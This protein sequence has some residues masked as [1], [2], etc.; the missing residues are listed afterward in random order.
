MPPR[1]K[2]LE[3]HGYKTFA[4]RTEFQ[5]PGVITAIVGPNGSGKSNIADAL[6]WVLGEQSF[7]LLRGRKTEDMIF[8][9]SEQRSRAGMASAT[10]TFDNADGWLPIDYSEVAITRRAYRDGQNEYLINGQRV[11]LRE[12]SELLA[13]SGLAERTYTIIGQGLVDAA[14][15]LKPE[16]RR[17]LFE[18]AAGIGL[19]RS[20]REESL[21]RLENTRRNLER[22]Q[23]ILVELEPRMRSLEKQARRVQES[24][25]LQAELRLL[26]RDLY[27]YQWHNAQGERSRAVEILRGQ[28][29]KADKARENHAT[30]NAELSIYR[31]QIQQLRG[32]LNEMHRQQSDLHDVREK[33]NREL[34]IL[35]ERQKALIEQRKSHGADLA[36]LEEELSQRQR[37]L[38]EISQ[39]KHR[40]EEELEEASGQLGK[41]RQALQE[42]Q[43][44]RVEADKTV[45]SLRQQQIATETRQVQ[46][47]ARQDELKHRVSQLQQS[48]ERAIKAVET[49]ELEA[50]RAQKALEAAV[51]KRQDAEAARSKTTERLDGGKKQIESFEADRRRLLDEKNRLDAQ[52]GR[53]SAQIEVIDQAEKSL[54]GV[55]E[56][57]KVLLQAAR[58]GRLRGKIQAISSLLDVPAEYETAIAA[59]LGEFLDV[60]F[61]N[62]ETDPEQALQMLDSNDKGRAALL[63]M[64]WLS[65]AR[66]RNCPSDPDCVGVAADLVSAPV[67]MRAAVDALL[68]RVLVVRDRPAARRL[69]AHE[70]GFS[71]YITLKGEVFYT[72]GL[73]Y[74]GK[75]TR[76]GALSKPR[77]KRELQIQMDDLKQQAGK[78]TADLDKVTQS[79]SRQREE[80]LRMEKEYQLANRVYEQANEQ[81]QQAKLS[82]EQTRRQVE[83][84]SGQKTNLETQISGAQKDLDQSN[85]DLVGIEEKITSLRDQVRQANGQLAA[86]PLDEFQAQVVHWNT[87][88]AVT[89]RGIQE[90]GKRLE[91]HVQN[92]ERSLGQQAGYKQRIAASEATLTELEEERSYLYE[93]EGENHQQIARLQ[94]QIDPEEKELERLEKGF[95]ELQEDESQAQQ[96]LALAERMLTQAQME[97]SRQKE[98]MDNLKHRIE[99]DFGLVVFEVSNEVPS[100]EPLPLEGMVEELP[101]LTELPANL[102]QEISRIRGQIRRLGAINPEAQTEYLE[103]SERFQFMTTQIADLRK[104][105]TDL[106]AVIAELDE[107]M[108][109]EFRKTFDAVAAEFKHLFTRLFGGGSARLTLIEA[110]NPTES[111]IEIETKLPGRREQGLSLLSGGERSLTAVA[112]VFSLLKV[113]PTPFCVMDEVDAML[114]EANVSRFRDLLR[115]LSLQTQFM[116]ITHN[117]NTV[118]AADVIYGITMGRDSASQIISLRLDELSEEMVK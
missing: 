10:I 102:E 40:M 22:V 80:Q 45:R 100:Q 75:E 97:L 61:L 34:A 81:R 27:G 94:K 87:L 89:S 1:L 43:N 30:I 11:R 86:L 116:V 60:L 66:R 112:L 73:I 82:A 118:Q 44:K 79:L 3:L 74:A 15:S 35:D 111:G 38:D 104:A 28:E 18:E 4:S 91:E 47:K 59:A 53:I 49:C 16:E 64:D 42:Q 83:W 48:L 52:Q 5:F 7:S 12:I 65:T 85:R 24:D 68:G 14:L 31:S 26:L 21:N 55:A 29:A 69:Q 110:D 115:E 25:R 105:D 41:A 2:S 84:Q 109:R 37:R 72:S 77:Q 96:V 19:Y 95:N 99:E 62:A 51:L 54:S 67:E 93:Q 117:R 98:S 23:D 101:V 33:I 13:R 32:R 103:V 20:R 17:K 46:I 36:R 88:Q 78:I 8:S 57:A 50:A 76:G 113:S 9:G 63:P 6:R 92:I 56:G 106:R 108:R 114:D 90:A 107:L 71:R 39:E 70:D 58:Q